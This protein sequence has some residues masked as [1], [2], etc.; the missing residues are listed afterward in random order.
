[1]AIEIAPRSSQYYCVRGYANSRLNDLQSAIRDY[2]E[3][4]HLNPKYLEAYVN[5][6]NVYAR[7][8]KH[9]L[10]IE[11]Y[12]KAINLN[13]DV[14]AIYQN[15]G[16][17]YA[18]S[19]ESHK[20]IA[21]RGAGAISQRRAVGTI[22]DWQQGIKLLQ[23][24]DDIYANTIRAGESTYILDV[25]D[26]PEIVSE[27]IEQIMAN[28]SIKKVFHNASFDLRYLG[29][30]ERA[31]NIT[32]TY[33]I[34]QK[35]SKKVLG[36]NNLKLKTLAVELCNFPSAKIANEQGSDWGK[37]PLSREQI[38]YAKMDTV[39]LARVHHCLLEF[40]PDMPLPQPSSFSV[41]D[42]RVAMR[43]P[44]LFYLNK[45]FG[46]KTLFTP[47][48]SSLGIGN[49]FHKLADEFIA[50]VKKQPQFKALFEP[51]ADQLPKAIATESIGRE[52]VETLKSFNVDVEYLGAIA[53]A[54]FIRIKLK[55]GKGVNS[56][57]P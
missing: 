26:K 46:G 10:A 27:F 29:G 1:M 13:P 37:R 50:T 35:I 36:T 52:L 44:R 14:V 5:R 15:R 49:T 51:P 55:P 25:L 22:A 3:T 53:G 54:T 6:G 12:T 33:K 47:T 41:T 21:K 39:Y 2:T 57:P 9:E 31:K 43:C 20:A 23:D 17:A 32:C 34:A 42:V 38:N 56:T 45:H 11:D 16:Q 48:S 19:Q 30:K 8:G 28:A 40:K 18:E 7:L 4:I 24:R